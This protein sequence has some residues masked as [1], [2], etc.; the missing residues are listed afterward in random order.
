[1]GFLD[2]DLRPCGLV[3][4]MPDRIFID[5]K[6]RVLSWTEHEDET[7]HSAYFS[8]DAVDELIQYVRHTIPCIKADKA[9]DKRVKPKVDFV[10]T[11]NLN[12]AL[13]RLGR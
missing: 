7:R 5:D 4:L 13:A 10:C 8:T 11:C 9:R 6:S 3:I 1:M 12:N 2:G